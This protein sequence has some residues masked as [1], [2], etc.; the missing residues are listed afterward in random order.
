[1][2]IL[3]EA[4]AGLDVHK[5]SV[6]ACVRRIDVGG[7]VVSE[8]REFNTMTEGILRMGDWM[9]AQGVRHAAME[10]TGVYWKPIWNLLEERFKLILCNA[11]DVKN[12]PGRKTATRDCQWLAQLLQHGLLRASFVPPKPHRELRD[13][14]RHRAQLTGEHTRAVNRIAKTLEDANIKLSSVASDIMGKSGR[15]MT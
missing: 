5:E 2:D 4:C 3:F 10:S 12:V 9:E 13:L 15:L 14:T 1:M 11:L 6:S 8:V 7:Q